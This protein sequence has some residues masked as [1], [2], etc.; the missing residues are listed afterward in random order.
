MDKRSYRERCT[1]WTTFVK[2]CRALEF[3]SKRFKI[4]CPVENLDLTGKTKFYKTLFPRCGSEPTACRL[5]CRYPRSEIGSRSEI[6][7]L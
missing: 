5:Y 6:G 4:R 7:V 3:A 1:E 2:H